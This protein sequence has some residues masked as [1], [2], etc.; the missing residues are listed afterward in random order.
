MTANITMFNQSKNPYFSTDFYETCTKMFGKRI[1][2]ILM[3]FSF[4]VAFPFKFIAYIYIHF[5]RNVDEKSDISAKMK[6]K[7][8]Y[9][10]F[11]CSQQNSVN[12]VMT[13]LTSNQSVESH[14]LF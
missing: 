11:F 10:Q 13:S 3:I 14:G 6:Q 12:D 2:F 7:N 5:N 8:I 9:T 4:R 1:S